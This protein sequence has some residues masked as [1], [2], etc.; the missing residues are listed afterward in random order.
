[1][2]EF[3]DLTVGYGRRVLVD[4]ASATL[5]ASRLTA[6][7]GRN[8]AG[9]SSL[10][11]VIAGLDAPLQ[12]CVKLGGENVYAMLPPARARKVAFVT[13]QRVRIP[14]LSCRDLVAMG[15]APYTGWTGRLS[16]DDMRV[17]DESL[18]AVGM[19]GYAARTMDKMSDGECQRVMI[20][21]ALAQDTPALLL[22]EPTS[23]LDMPNRYELCLLLKRLARQRGKTIIFSTHELDIALDIA[24]DI[25][26]IDSPRL[27]CG[28]VDEVLAVGAIERLFSSPSMRFDTATRK[29]IFKDTHPRTN[30]I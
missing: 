21:R 25:M 11:R 24:D 27:V 22:D 2:I 1:M 28:P 14:R 4:K 29:V 19:E 7:I 9:K 5:G 6:L 23:F 12:G 18:A 17:V 13:T 16:D 20:A 10:L 26:L 30:E 3:D 15:R 8:G